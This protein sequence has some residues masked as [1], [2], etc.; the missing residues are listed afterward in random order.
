LAGVLL[1]REKKKRK[2]INEYIKRRIEEGR[3]RNGYVV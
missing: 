1:G 3:I 2:K